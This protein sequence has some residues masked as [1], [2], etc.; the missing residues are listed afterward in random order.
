MHVAL[1]GWFWDQPH[2]G[3]GQIIRRLLPQL[4]K[5]APEV[6]LTLVLPPRIMP[7]EDRPP[8][9]EVIR[10]GR[11]LA[12]GLG[13]RAGK[14]WF[15]QRGFPAAV[16]RCGADIAHVPY[17]GPPL[18]SPARLITSILDLAPVR[19]PE[20]G[21]GL[22]NRLYNALVTAGA[23]GSAHTLTLSQTAKAEIVEHLGLAPETITPV[24]LGVDEH[25]HPR[26]G[27][28]RD[29]AVRRK[30]DLPDRFVLAIGGF[31]RRK[32]FN[33][34]LLAYTYVV[35]GEGDTVPLVM[36]GREPKWGTPVF[37]DMRRY[38]QQLDLADVVRWIGYVDEEDKPS[39]YR[40]ASVFAFPSGYEGFGLPPLEAMAS[41]TPV[42]AWEIDVN[43]EILGDAAY[44]VKNARGLA[45]AILALLEQ[46]TFRQSM[47]NQG[48]A[49]ATRYTWR[50]TAQ[51]TLAVYE[52]V[53]RL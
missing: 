37:P 16:R 22:P 49:Q 41:G 46:E 4:R 8:G 33:E 1:N 35:Q 38:A 48:L 6:R 31:D 24:Y 18:S 39:L 12:D 2:T 27:A 40:L 44:L 26:I 11:S 14:V 52:Q 36:A 50:K 13:T 15:E 17:W 29:E 23:G 43:Q 34:L 32:Q 5:I 19:I 9:V 51:E 21:R 25:F 20:Y 45:G 3:S 47:I 10:V 42:V 28:E 30:Y 53:M 7:G